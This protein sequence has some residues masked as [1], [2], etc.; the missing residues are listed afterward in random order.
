[1]PVR[2]IVVLSHFQ[3]CFRDL[4]TYQV[5]R[6]FILPMMP[7]EM[8]PLSYQ[9]GQDTTDDDTGA[10]DTTN[11]VYDSSYVNQTNTFDYGDDSTSY[12]N[13]TRDKD[14]DRFRQ[15]ISSPI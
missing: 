15:N 13:D 10:V 5:E 8:V 4:I 7:P 14:V 3:V 2:K 9:Q 12:A 1:M 6:D 11:Q